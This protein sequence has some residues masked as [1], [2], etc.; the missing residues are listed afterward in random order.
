MMD[1]FCLVLLVFAFA[2]GLYCGLWIVLKSI[3]TRWEDCMHF[4]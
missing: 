1:G 3:A 2:W 4:D